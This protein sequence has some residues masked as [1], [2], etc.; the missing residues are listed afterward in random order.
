MPFILREQSFMYM[1]RGLTAV[2]EGVAHWYG[3]I[4]QSPATAGQCLMYVLKTPRMPSASQ[5]N[6][7]SLKSR[8]ADN[9]DEIERISFGLFTRCIYY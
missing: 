7:D 8:D 3:Y 2:V 5:R 1:C 9:V 6:G 4:L